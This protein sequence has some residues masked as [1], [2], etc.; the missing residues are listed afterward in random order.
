MCN[1][2]CP[3]L[4]R[5]QCQKPCLWKSEVVTP[6]CVPWAATVHL[7]TKGTIL[8]PLLAAAM[9]PTVSRR[10]RVHRRDQHPSL[11]SPSDHLAVAEAVPANLVAGAEVEVVVAAMVAV[12]VHHPLHRH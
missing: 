5:R 2:L 12:E 4:T 10:L 8:T 9:I 6:G 1:P 7:M 11:S 3:T